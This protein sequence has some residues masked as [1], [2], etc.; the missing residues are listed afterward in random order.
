M[1][2]PQVLFCQA[3]FQ[4]GSPQHVLVPGV[5]PP[6]VQ[7]FPL[8]FVELHEV[9]D[10]PFLQPVKIPPDGSMILWFISLC[11]QFGVICKLAEGTLYPIIQIINED[12]KQDWTQY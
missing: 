9:P 8:P 4:L 6:Q 3:A 10:S 1:Q 7:D 2:D 12:V 5:V 11:S